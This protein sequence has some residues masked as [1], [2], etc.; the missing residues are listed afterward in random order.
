M[1]AAA[2]RDDDAAYALIRGLGVTNDGA[3]KA[4]YAAPGVAGQRAAVVSALR[5]AG[6]SALSLIHI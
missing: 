1:A 2:A 6:V 4:G 3:R 5:M